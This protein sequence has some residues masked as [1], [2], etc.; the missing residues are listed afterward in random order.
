M[1]MS[2]TWDTLSLD[3][4]LALRTAA[5]RLATEFRGIFG[6]ETIERFLRSSLDQFAVHATV[7]KFLP[8]MADR[9]ARQ[10]LRALVQGRGFARRR[11]A[12]RAVP[13]RAQRRPRANGDG[14]L[15]RVGR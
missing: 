7:V 15:H 1:I 8:L 14:V 6:T 10:R 11:Q 3:E 13:V 9:F 12:D 5:A 4:S 2:P